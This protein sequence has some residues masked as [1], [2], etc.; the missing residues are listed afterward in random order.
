MLKE[1]ILDRRGHE[2]K[3]FEQTE[4]WYLAFTI[5]EAAHIF[6]SNGIKIG[7]IRP[8]NIFINDN[9]HTKVANHLSWPNEHDNYEKV[10]FNKEVTYL[11]TNRPIQLPKKSS[12]LTLDST[13]LGD[14]SR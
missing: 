6:H 5:V 13:I 11:G 4:L 7:D 12:T 3:Y 2:K 10:L 8:L 9:G 1:E 14:T